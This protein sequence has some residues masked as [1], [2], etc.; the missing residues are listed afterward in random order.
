MEL[1]KLGVALVILEIAEFVQ[2]LDF[3]SKDIFLLR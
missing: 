3:W 2:V 1:Y